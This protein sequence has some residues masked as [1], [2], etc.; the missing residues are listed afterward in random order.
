MTLVDRRVEL[1]GDDH[2]PPDQDEREK[3]RRCDPECAV[4]V[5]SI[6]DQARGHVDVEDVHEQQPDAEQ[7]GAGK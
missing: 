4:G 3:E 6:L 2:H 7:R 5:G 1:R